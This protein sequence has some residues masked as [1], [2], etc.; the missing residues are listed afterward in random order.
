MKEQG[1]EGMMV[2]EFEFYRKVRAFY[3]NVSFSLSFI[4]RFSHRV[5][6]SAT[7]KGTFSCGVNAH[8]QTVE[9]LMQ[10]KSESIERPYSE[11][12]SF[13]FSN[14]Y[15]AIPEQVIDYMNYPIHKLRYR[16]PIDYD[17][18]QFIVEG[19]E[20]AINV[21]TMNGLFKKWKLL[22]TSG[23]PVDAHLKV[24]KVELKW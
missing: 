6:K 19:A 18:Q 4:Y 14:I 13:L 5:N 22:G 23:Q 7:A 10:L 20:S 17:W 3:C 24:T 2:E 8:T 12:G 21:N 11:S 9:Y 16:V 1:E 15:E